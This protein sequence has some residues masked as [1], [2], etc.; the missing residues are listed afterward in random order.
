MTNKTDNHVEEGYQLPSVI[1]VE[2]GTVSIPTNWD[3]DSLQDLETF[4]RNLTHLL[5]LLPDSD[6]AEAEFDSDEEAYIIKTDNIPALK[7][8]VKNYL[9]DDCF[10]V[11]DTVANHVLDHFNGEVCHECVDN[12]IDQALDDSYEAVVLND[13]VYI[14]KG[15][16]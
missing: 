10:T 4:N 9:I 14:K 7:F 13:G 6:K 12:L 15:G 1:K 16:L 3:V 2:V 5:A 11:I 8:S